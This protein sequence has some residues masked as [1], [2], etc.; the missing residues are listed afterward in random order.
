MQTLRGGRQVLCAFRGECWRSVRFAENAGA[1]WFAENAGALW[2]AANA[3]AL[4]FAENASTL[5]FT[6]DAAQPVLAETVQPFVLTAA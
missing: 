5:W 3:G 2:F 4:C 1:L 6:E